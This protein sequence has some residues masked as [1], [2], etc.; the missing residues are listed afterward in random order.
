MGA[1]LQLAG[2]AGSPAEVAGLAAYM[3]SDEA[4]FVTGANFDTDGGFMLKA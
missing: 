3:L 4:S 1:G 2:R